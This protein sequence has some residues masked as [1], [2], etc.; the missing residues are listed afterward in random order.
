MFRDAKI[1]GKLQYTPNMN[2]IAS[3]NLLYLRSI[4]DYVRIN[5]MKLLEM[6]TVVTA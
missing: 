6:Y 1:L 2:K 3:S 5:N 4:H